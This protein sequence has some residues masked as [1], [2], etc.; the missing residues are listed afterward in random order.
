MSVVLSCRKFPVVRYSNYSERTR[1]IASQL[2]ASMHSETD[3]LVKS[4]NS[5]EQ[6]VILVLDRV[7]DPVT[8]LL[9]QWTYQSM[10][11]E[12]VGIRHHRVQLSTQKEEIVCNPEFD[13]FFREN[14]Y[15]NYGEL[16]NNM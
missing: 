11:H 9:N 13:D 2:S 1:K 14:M 4:C 15:L 10:I 16:C 8:P 7:D 12:L 6:S 5:D 3:L